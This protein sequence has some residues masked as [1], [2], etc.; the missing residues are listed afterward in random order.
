M[1]AHYIEDLQE[2]ERVDAFY[3]VQSKEVRTKKNSGEPYLSLILSDRTGSIETKMWDG[4]EAIADLFDKDDFVKVRAT[5]QLYRDKPQLV[6]HKLRR[7]EDGEIDLDDFIPHT[8]QDIGEMWATLRANVEA[9]ENPHLKA[10]LLA[11]L[12]DPEF[13]DR[14]ATPSA[15]VP[16]PAT[17]RSATFVRST[18]ACSS[19][20]TRPRA[21]SASSCSAHSSSRADSSRCAAAGTTSPALRS[22]TRSRRPSSARSA[23]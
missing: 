22:V 15:T 11:F 14:F 23:P 12:D 19:A 5:V 10:L 20:L 7:A 16:K 18:R 17:N 6:V 21:T 13:A 8:K 4:V 2:N 9:F 1:K 3:L